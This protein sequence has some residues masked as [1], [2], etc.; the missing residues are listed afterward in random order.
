MTAFVLADHRRAFLFAGLSSVWL[1]FD[2]ITCTMQDLELLD[3]GTYAAIR[4][5]AQQVIAFD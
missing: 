5:R 1:G 4:A 2:L 3:A